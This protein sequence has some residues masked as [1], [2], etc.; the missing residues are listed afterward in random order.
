MAQARL[1]NAKLAA[2]IAETGWSHAQV[3]NAFVR[4]ASENGAREFVGVGRSHVSH[5]VSGSHPSGW[6]PV[7]FVKPLSRRLGRTVTLD[8]VGFTVQSLSS[9][10]ALDCVWIP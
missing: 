8:E 6:A 1:G 5:W 7:I 2:V 4:V 9:R 10:A 3:A